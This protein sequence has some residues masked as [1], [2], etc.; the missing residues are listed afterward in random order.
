[1]ANH[2]SITDPNEV[3][4]A[5]AVLAATAGENGYYLTVDYNGGGGAQQTALVA[6]PTAK[7]AIH[8]C[9]HSIDVDETVGT[10]YQPASDIAPIPVDGTITEILI[11]KFSFPV[12]DIKIDH[13][14]GGASGAVTNIFTG[15]AA[16]ADLTASPLPLSVS[17]GDVITVTEDST[18]TALT[19]LGPIGITFF[20]EE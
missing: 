20:V 14:V 13:F 11:R 5:K 9:L 16:D 10:V 6:P 3:H 2:V 15:T 18:G 12:G 4:E 17:K 7:H 8:M 19:G 1:M